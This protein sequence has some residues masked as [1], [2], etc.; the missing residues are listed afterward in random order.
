MAGGIEDEDFTNYEP[1]AVDPGWEFT[2]AIIVV[3]ILINLSLPL[4][5]RAGDWWAMRRKLQEAPVHEEGEITLVDDH[6][7]NRKKLTTPNKS[8]NHLHAT[9][10]S[11]KPCDCERASFVHSKNLVGQYDHSPGPSS[12][13][14][15][16]VPSSTVLSEAASVLLDA[17][18]KR[19]RLP[20]KHRKRHVRSPIE[21]HGDDGLPHHHSSSSH[22]HN[23]DQRIH[24]VRD[25]AELA[26]ADLAFQRYAA[27]YNDEVN[28]QH[29]DGAHRD[30]R[31]DV[32]PSVLS[33]LDVDEIS[34][35][36]AV[37][38]KD[39]GALATM[40]KDGLPGDTLLMSD[41]SGGLTW[42]RMLEIADWDKEM[43]KFVALAVPFSVQGLA[44]ELLGIV[45]VAIV[46]H[47]I[48]VM[49]ANAFVV[50]SIMLEFTTTLTKGFAEF[51]GVL[52]PHADGAGNDLLV[53]RYL[54]LGVIFYTIMTIP[55]VIIWGLFT[56]EAV[57][58]FGFDEATAVIGQ[59]YAYTLL[60]YLFVEGIVGCLTEF[61]NTLDHEGYATVFTI[62]ATLAES[63]AI[64]VIAIMGVKDLVVVGLVQVAVGCI[65][66]IINLALI[67]H[68]GWLER[69]WEGIIRTNGLRDRRAVH[70]V[71][72][73]GIPL[74]LAWL[75]TFGEWE[76]MTLFARHMG[77]AE[78][79]AWGMI[80]YVWSAFETVTDGF[81]DAAEVRVGFRMGAGQPGIA[82]LVGEKSIYIGLAV[83]VYESGLVFVIAEYL[84][85]LLTPDP[86]LQ[87]MLFEL[88]PLIGFAQILMV[89]GMEAWAVLG[90]QGRVRLATV[91]EFVVSWFIGV[92]LSA[93]FVF[94]FNFNL[95]SMVASLTIAYTVGANVYLYT[96]FTSDWE[97]L[98]A[99]VVARNFAE[100]VLYDEFDWDDLPSNIQEAAATLGYTEE[101]W[102]NDQEPNTSDKE[103]DLLTE[104]EKKAAAVLGFNRKKWDMDSSTG[105]DSGG[106][107]YDDMDWSDLPQNVKK[108]AQTLGY[109]E[110][111][112]NNDQDC[113][114]EDKKWREL[115]SEQKN[116]AKILGYNRRLWDKGSDGLPSYDHLNWVQLPSEVRDA[117][118]YLKY[119]QNIWDK[120]GES[121]LE[122]KEWRELTSKQKEAARVLGYDQLKW[123][124][125]MD[126]SDSD[127]QDECF[128]D[129]Q[130]SF[131]EGKSTSH[132]STAIPA[133]RISDNEKSRSSK[134][135]APAHGINQGKD[136]L[137]CCDESTIE[138]IEYDEDA[139]WRKLPEKV[140]A[141]A[142]VLGYTKE[143]WD[144]DKEPPTCDKS[145]N[146][147]TME[148]KR[149]AQV[150]G[151]NKEKWDDDD[152]DDS[153][154]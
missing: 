19:S 61:L 71:V 153:E 110:S 16:S 18:P 8:D 111:M 25:A 15:S 101:L 58:W 81:G 51:I 33:K 30:D 89:A 104:E 70:T 142:I 106:E 43:K 148:E 107:G 14:S 62:I 119:S 37:D 72:I 87:K 39:A 133:S 4:W 9:Q 36:D 50:V 112:W 126:G 53:G 21:G 63:V 117:A 143:I 100:G 64:A 17:R 69:Y 59:D 121:P 49:E 56:E 55:G 99:V 147:L 32:T 128:E 80:G 40:K 34:V 79:A 73:T 65:A 82:K 68:K 131:N 102:N 38:A 140:Q 138:P 95:E 10:A 130:E 91:I 90:A 2:A 20:Q 145:W 54:Q 11:A 132:G 116:A 139:S 113:P 31:S 1:T 118:K 114:L 84:P 35:H 108:A 94:G 78:V 85:A 26:T 129:A 29:Q 144:E 127:S 66:L 124:N 151:Y 22:N 96:L 146:A 41:G 152:S 3:C 48:G 24:A 109:T 150:L 88:I 83:A 120:D 6:E 98:S 77:P 86:T 67:I 5:L 154:V 52:V 76:V 135:T 28:K 45:N 27:M 103:W 97:A 136:I 141:A 134:G 105:S 122:E 137:K 74:G 7:A 42:T 75:M 13:V 47:F 93:A 123:D 92:P 46:G 57:L 44:V 115:T 149:A 60:F 125:D 23:H 12:V